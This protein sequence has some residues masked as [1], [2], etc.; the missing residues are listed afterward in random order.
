MSFHKTAWGK[1]RDLCN[2]LAGSATRLNPGLGLA[3]NTASASHIGLGK[4]DCVTAAAEIEGS[5][6]NE[7]LSFGVGEWEQLDDVV[8]RV[9]TSRLSLT[10]AKLSLLIGSV[11]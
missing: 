3:C 9:I 7:K 5:A 11:G 1:A 8:R 4:G 6:R 2:S 10:H